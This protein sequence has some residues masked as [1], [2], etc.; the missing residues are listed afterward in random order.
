MKL[1]FELKVFNLYARRV[2]KSKTDQLIKGHENA[3]PFSPQEFDVDDDDC[4]IWV[5]FKIEPQ[6]FQPK[7]F[8]GEWAFT[9]QHPEPGKIRIVRMMTGT[10]G[11]TRAIARQGSKM[12]A[13]PWFK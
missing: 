4:N 12:Y 13:Y 3:L 1:N 5:R 9:Q 7:I 10:D 6:R 8:D 2:S 11:I